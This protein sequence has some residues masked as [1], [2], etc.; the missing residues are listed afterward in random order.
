MARRA[1]IRRG[2]ALPVLQYRDLSGGLNTYMSATRIKDNESPDLQNIEFLENGIPAK[3]RGTDVY[4]DA[5]NSRVLGMGSLYT[6]GGTRRHLQV[7]GTAL[8]YYNAGTW[9]SIAGKTFTASKLANF[10]QCQD[11]IYVHN[12]TDSMGKYD[13]TTLSSPSVGVT[14]CKFGIFY[15]GRHCAAGKSTTPSRLYLSSTK[16]ADNFVGKTGTATAGAASTIT[17]TGQAWTTNEYAGLT[18]KITAGT[19]AGQERTIASN[20]ATVITV[21]TAWTTN[22]DTTSTYSIEGGDTIDINKNDGQAITGLAKFEEKLII[23]KERSI[24]QLTFDSLGFPTVQLVTATAGCVSHRSIEHV[25]NDIFYL[26]HDGVRTFGYVPNI[27]AVRTNLLTAKVNTEI[28]NIN[29]TYYESCTAIYQ[30][31]KFLFSYPYGSS[32]TN[33]R[34][35]V[36]HMLYGCW[37]KWTGL[38]VNSFN[39]FGSVSGEVKLYYGHETNGQTY[40]MLVD[41]YSDGA[42]TA[43]DA[44]W[45]S[46]EFDLGHFDQ[47]KR[48]VFL[49][50]QIRSLVGGLGVQI[51]GNGSEVLFDKTSGVSSTFTGDDGLRSFTFRA[52]EFREDEGSTATTVATDDIRRVRLNKTVRTI[53]I[54]VYNSVVDERFALLSLAIGARLRSPYSFDSSKVIN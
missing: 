35:L 24:W 52:N 19:G 42:S 49:D 3:R 31:N 12:G 53:K 4:G 7:S 17:D 46:K 40:E 23:F 45:C 21:S 5:P 39:H 34:M 18:I 48:I 29:T 1:R 28:V 9:T 14:G 13:G 27:E 6:S 8:Y 44:Y 16:S 51:I 43:I 41:N 38:P 50:L 25:E 10:V 36:Y 33:D 26:S 47:R 32:T 54:K 22:P 2:S 20:T 11:A 37:S 15:A 30:D